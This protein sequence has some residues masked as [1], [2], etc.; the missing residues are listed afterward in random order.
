MLATVAGQ[1]LLEEMPRWQGRLVTLPR[2]SP[3][4]GYSLLLGR[5][6][7]YDAFTDCSTGSVGLQKLA[8]LYLCLALC[9]PNSTC[10]V[11]G[12]MHARSGRRYMCAVF[13]TSCFDLL[14]RSLLCFVP[15]GEVTGEV[16]SFYR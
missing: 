8:D 3:S 16:I 9:V 10:S 14:D 6:S 13:N 7:L 5:R 15:G 4:S 11:S 2:D 1:L 12:K